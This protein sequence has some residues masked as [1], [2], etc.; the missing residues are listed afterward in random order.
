[1]KFV[2]F[3][4]K[5][6]VLFAAILLAFISV[7]FVRPEPVL[8]FNS[9]DFRVICLL[10]CLMIVIQAFRTTNLLDWIAQKLLSYNKNQNYD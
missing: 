6:P 1:M 5:E 4:K 9:I 2:N 8:V 7:L 3:I 10:F